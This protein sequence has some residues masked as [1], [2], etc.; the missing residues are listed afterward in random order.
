MITL[1]SDFGSQDAYVGV[2]KG[3]MA[4]ITPHV[5]MCDLT[6][7]IAPQDILAARFNLKTAYP[8]FPDK[9]VHLVV[10]DPGVGTTRRAVAVRC[11]N[12]ALCCFLVGPDNGVLSGV[13]E[14]FMGA[15][16][17]P[18][19]GSSAV[20]AG[21][22]SVVE[23]TNSRYWRAGLADGAPSA[24]FHGRDIFAPVAAHLANGVALEALG[25]RV[26][27]QTLVKADI[28]PF[29]LRGH[30]SPS[31]QIAV[32]N[33][34]V[35]DGARGAGSDTE[36]LSSEG[37]MIGVGCIQYVD[38]FGNLISNIPGTS[39][40]DTM[41]KIL[42]ETP[43]E[44]RLLPCIKTYGDVPMGRLAALVGSHGWIEVVCNG[45]SAAAALFAQ[46]GAPV[47][48]SITVTVA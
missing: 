45:G 29:Y 34:N 10:V 3:V 31:E 13:I 42:L 1:L 37:S 21:E 40:A 6:H 20:G 26:D 2:M 25:D 38:R 14:D 22:V 35:Q 12:A 47:G 18:V 41:W 46:G 28:P 36:C 48:M 4:A 16:G 15:A 32:Q 19:V 33:M 30:A 17:V 23:L 24:T 44:P 43:L 27:P 11:V 7:E 39:V 9:T 8:Y 5:A